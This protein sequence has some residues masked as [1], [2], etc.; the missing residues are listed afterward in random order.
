MRD[1]S[2]TQSAVL[3]IFCPDQKGITTAVTGFVTRHHGNIL[4]ADQHIDDH[5][6]TF[7][8]RIE[9]DLKDFTL[10]QS[11]IERSFQPIA[12]QFKMHWRFS[13]TI[14]PDRVA[15]FVSKH[16]HCLN[17][18]LYRYQYGQLP[19]TVAMV[20]SNHPEARVM[21]EPYKIPFYEV[22]ITPETKR[23]QEA[24]EL[25]LLKAADIDLIV[26]ARYHQI[27]SPEFVQT[28]PHQ[29][30]N[31]HHSFLP[32]FVGRKPYHQAY[33]KGVKIIGATAHYVTED[34]DQGPIIEQ[35]TVRISHRDK[36]DDLIRKGE[37]LEKVV[38]HRA[39]RWH[40]QRKILC[41][42]RKT[43]IFD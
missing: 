3:R 25:K 23:D 7:F 40:L 5:T 20:I 37:D 11:G 38:F 22:P 14:Q 27:L 18:L 36:V 4:H 32:A 12:E 17:D 42:G 33:E 2:S 43:V 9:W 39:I 1:M 6:N 19:C 35:D 29:I 16:L 41:Y 21:V 34:L 15:I 10:D 8:M 28:Y 13:T 26:L 30:I 31:I 24:Q